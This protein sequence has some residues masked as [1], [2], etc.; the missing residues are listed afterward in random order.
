M[1]IFGW[2]LPPG[3]TTRHIEE[4]MGESDVC[5]ICGKPVDDCICPGCKFCGEQGRPECYNPNSI[6]FHEMM[7]TPE[8]CAS[9]DAATKEAGMR[10]D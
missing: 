6:Y 8:Q 10:N 2:D 1:G 5:E 3:C 7:R 4:A 9:Y